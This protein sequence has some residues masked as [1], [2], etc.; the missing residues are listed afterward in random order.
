MPRTALDPI[1]YIR[2]RI[3]ILEAQIEEID[4]EKESRRND[5]ESITTA[6]ENA[7]ATYTAALLNEEMLERLSLG[8]DFTERRQRM[9]QIIR[10]VNNGLFD[11]VRTYKA[12]LKSLN[13]ERRKLERDVAVLRLRLELLQT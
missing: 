12:F 9:H 8:K 1:E 2:K 7:K 13:A 3:E 5:Y 6:F 11:E 4:A 10:G